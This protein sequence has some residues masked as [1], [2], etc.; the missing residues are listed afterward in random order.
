MIGAMTGVAGPAAENLI[1][2]EPDPG[3]EKIVTGWRSYFAPEKGL[4]MGFKT[5]ASFADNVRYFFGRRY[6]LGTLCNQRLHLSQR[7][8]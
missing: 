6:R 2:W 3:A 5:D 4:A 1:T 8:H 7:W